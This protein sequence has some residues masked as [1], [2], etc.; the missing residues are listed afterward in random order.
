[1]LILASSA[2]SFPVAGEHEGVDLDHAGVFLHV[3]AVTRVHQCGERPGLGG[4]ELQLGGEPASLVGLEADGGVDGLGEDL[5][6]LR[7]GDLLDLHAARCR[8][9]DDGPPPASVGR[10]AQVQ[11]ALDIHRLLDEH[12]VYRSALRTG[13][14]G[15]EGRAD[16]GLS[17]LGGLGG[18]VGYLHA[19]GFA[20]S[21]GVYLRFDDAPPTELGR[22]VAG[23]ITRRCDE[24]LGYGYAIGGQELLG[25]VFVELHMHGPLCELARSGTRVSRAVGHDTRGAPTGAAPPP[26]PSFPRRREPRIP[27]ALRGCQIP[28]PLRG[29]G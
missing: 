3:G 4:W 20:A 1:M 5:L 10:D 9:D 21:S 19:S 25:L 7:L 18:V 14:E 11:F 16:K 29:E 28:S 27:A 8:R 23:F 26:L 22:R 24:V 2:R 13:L 17:D 12:L 6:R 15:N